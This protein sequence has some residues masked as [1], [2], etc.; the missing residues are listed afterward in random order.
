MVQEVVEA[1][2][3]WR[4]LVCLSVCMY[5]CMQEAETENMSKKKNE[6]PK[7]KPQV[8]LPNSAHTHTPTPGKVRGGV[9]GFGLRAYGLGL[10]RV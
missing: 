9:Q 3:K 2:I 6:P 5:V 4:R 10:L 1:G 8:C 7:K